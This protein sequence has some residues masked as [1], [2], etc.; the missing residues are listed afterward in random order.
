MWLG[1]GCVCFA[2]AVQITVGTV[3]AIFVKPRWYLFLTWEEPFL[4]GNDTQLSVDKD[5]QVQSNNQI[6]YINNLDIRY[7]PNT[8]AR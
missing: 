2:T 3:P 5:E 4:I 8:L 7:T 6:K 1:G